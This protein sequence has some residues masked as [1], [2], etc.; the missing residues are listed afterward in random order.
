MRRYGRLIVAVAILI[1][2]AGCGN[3]QQGAETSAA[4]P[5]ATAPP[6]RKI[7]KVREPA[8]AGQFYPGD[9]QELADQI[10][11]YLAKVKPTPIKNLRGLVCPH[12][13]YIYSGQTAAY[14]YKQLSGVPVKT[15]VVMAPSH[16]VWLEGASIP[17]ADAYATPLGM[18]LL[19]PRAAE[20]AKR[21]P[22]VRS[23]VVG[24]DSP[25]AREHSLEVQLP[26][27]QRTLKDFAIVPMVLG[28]VD[29]EEVA[30]ALEGIIDPSTVVVASSD[31]SHFHPYD[32][33]V[34][35][36]TS[37]VE[38]ICDLDVKRMEKEEAC[39]KLP[40]LTLMHIARKK[41]WKAKLLDYRNS[42]DVT[43]ELSRVVGYAAVAFYDPGDGESSAETTAGSLT[44]QEGKVLLEL[45]RKTVE[46]VVRHNALPEMDAADVPESLKELRA[47]FVTLTKEGELRGCIGSLSPR[48]P[49]WQAVIARARSA[50]VEDHRFP[51]VAPAELDELE[52]EVSVLTVPRRLEYD[53][54]EELLGKLR[55]GVDGVVLMAGRRQATYLP[56]VWEK[57][58]DGEEFLSHLAQKAG[59]PPS[60]WRS[61]DV[62]ILVYQ[63]E[64]FKQPEM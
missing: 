64:A 61:P 28:D 60:A 42:G 62:T 54:P 22:F 51:P 37:C 5:E 33:A 19:S 50:A 18:V 55:P 24:S 27:L 34:E 58:P 43:G 39:G 14:A 10:D 41:G 4:E 29:P 15:V 23:D 38:A 32:V 20:L 11:E 45:A 13:G 46:E 26:F 21:R 6:A 2:L 47:C 35:L 57:L 53:S 40:V 7:E 52:I 44:P 9:Q 16:R 1:G 25:H 63:V 3:D 12:A 17:D 48:E 30:R 8:V 59:L 56:Q 36:D 31:L 49:L